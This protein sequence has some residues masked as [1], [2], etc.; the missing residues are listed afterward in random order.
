MEEHSQQLVTE[1]HKRA[2]L[3]HV[4]HWR[5]TC[6][7]C[8]TWFLWSGGSMLICSG[9]RL[10]TCC[11][12]AFSNSG[13]N[14]TVTNIRLSNSRRKSCNYFI[15]IRIRKYMKNNYRWWSLRLNARACLPRKLWWSRTLTY[16][17]I[18]K[19]RHPIG[20]SIWLL[21]TSNL[22]EIHSQVRFSCLEQQ[23][24]ICFCY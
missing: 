21:G 10:I 18:R 24:Y 9:V 4:L 16:C 13:V 6:C 23:E 8:R 7:N 20:S 15:D 3:Q 1:N 17:I 14:C 19:T 12:S 5:S 11:S 2:H 22:I